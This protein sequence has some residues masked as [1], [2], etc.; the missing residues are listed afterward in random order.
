MRALVSGSGGLI[1][2]ECVS[3]L[4]EEGWEVA[5][6]DNDMRS[7]FFG[8]EAST[9]IVFE[10]LKKTYANYV[11]WE[12]DIRDRRGIRDLFDSFKPSFI[13]HCAGQPSHEAAASML[14]LDFS[15][16]A[17]GTLNLIE[18]ARDYCRES[19]FCYLST[20]KVY[21]D[22][23]NSLGLV[24]LAQR[25]DFADGRHGI[26][27]DLPIDQ[28]LHSFFGVSKASADLLCQEFG[29]RYDMPVGIFRAGCVS[30][31]RHAAVEFHGYLAHII[32]CAVSHRSYT[33][34]GYKGKQVR[35]QIHC[36]DL[37]RLFLEFFRRP[38]SAEVYNVGGGRANSISILETIRLL[39]DIGLVLE[40]DY[41]PQHRCGDHICYYSDLEKTQ[42]HFP[43]WSIEHDVRSIACEISESRTRAVGDFLVGSWPRGRQGAERPS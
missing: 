39:E 35:D 34:H 13:V 15:V 24:E 18:A 10:E 22:R 41:S 37:A 26:A 19:P 25:Y 38:R 16:N 32:Q 40:Y 8:T 7:R 6:V 9:R 27:E 12:L 5:G 3:L 33:I 31:P 21:G 36:R 2:S 28:C 30:G 29:R 43:G 20:N 11:H 14:E 23:P 1:G 17:V 42:R 4:C